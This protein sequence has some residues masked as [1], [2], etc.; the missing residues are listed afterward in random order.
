M[1]LSLI[2]NITEKDKIPSMW[3]T[4]D[5]QKRFPSSPVIGKR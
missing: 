1:Y 4:A 2:V 5:L 3:F